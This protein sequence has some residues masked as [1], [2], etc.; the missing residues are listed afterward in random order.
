MVKSNR[1]SPTNKKFKSHFENFASEKTKKGHLNKNDRDADDTTILT[2]TLKRINRK[3]LY[4]NGWEVEVDKKVYYCTYSTN[5]MSIPTST[6]TDTYFIPKKKCEVEIQVDKVSK[7]YTISRI[8]DVN[9][10]PIALYDNVVTISSNT[11]TNTNDDSIANISV[12]RTGVNLSGE[13]SISDDVTIKG[14]VSSPNITM[15][16]EKISNL[17]S[18]I[19]S[20][21]SLQQE[22]IE[23]KKQI[24]EIQSKTEGDNNDG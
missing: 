1:Y 16:E 14:N 24:E 2:G 11:N 13:I 22:I 10:T 20:D 15:L 5:V 3:K 19:N 12:T 23:L 9:L 17:E 7:I 8:K 6:V 18:Q 4:D 21:N